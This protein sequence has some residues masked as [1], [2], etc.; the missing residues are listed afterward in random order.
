MMGQFKASD[1]QPLS[2]SSTSH[3]GLQLVSQESVIIGCYNNAVSL[4]SHT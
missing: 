3:Y 2:K 4:L 1:S